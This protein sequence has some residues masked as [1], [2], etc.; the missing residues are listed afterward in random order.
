MIDHAR[1]RFAGTTFGRAGRASRR[2]SA[3]MLGIAVL[4][5]SMLAPAVAQ[6]TGELPTRVG[7]LSSF[8]GQV[9]IAPPDET[10]DWSPIDLNYPVTGGDNLWTG[11]GARAEIELGGSQLRMSASTNVNVAALDDHNLD[12]F[13]AQG[14]IIVRVA[15]LEPGDSAVIDTP[16]TQVVLR[17]P[18]LYRVFVSPDQQ[19]TSV[20]VREGE[21][22]AQVSAGLQQVLPGQT[23]TI[24]NAPTTAAQFSAAAPL[25]AFD[26]WSADRERTFRAAAP[27]YVSTQMV[28]YADLA[29]Y[30]TWQS[31]PDY[32]NV[33]FPTT[34][35]A[36]WAP[37]SDGYWTTIPG[38]G[39]T[40]VDRA[41]WGYAPFHYGRWV[42]VGARWGWVPGTYV[43]RPVWAPALVAWTGG[44]ITIAIGGGGPVYG[45]VPLGW[46]EPYNPWW[47]GC[48]GGC[49]DRY[50][51]PYRVDERYRD[52]APPP[53]R[54]ANWRVPGAV[55]A[56]A[57][58]NLIARKP[59]AAR[60]RV[61]LTGTQLNAVKP[62]TSVPPLTHARP[63][64]PRQV[65]AGAQGT[66]KPA[67]DFYA[68]S[69]PARLGIAHPN[70]GRGNGGAG[71][72]NNAAGA[73][74]TTAPR[75]RSAIGTQQHEK[76]EEA[77]V[78]KPPAATEVHAA[79]KGVGSPNDNNRGASRGGNAQPGSAPSGNAGAP[80]GGRDNRNRHA[81]RTPPAP[82]A[83]VAPSGNAASQGNP[84]AGAPRGQVTS[85]GTTN[86]SGQRRSESAGGAAR[87]SGNPQAGNAQR[88]G[89]GQHGANAQGGG[90]AQHGGSAQGGN[91][92][93]G[94]AT[95]QGGASAQRSGNAQGGGNV[96]RSG[97]PQGGANA[98][99]QHGGGNPQGGGNAH[100]G[101][102]NPQHE[103]KGGDNRGRNDHDNRNDRNDKQ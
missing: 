46:R 15:V 13:V 58:A 76:A 3:R 19:Q 50:N 4:A 95:P 57:G 10:Q 48:R 93:Q 45:W 52:H 84:A 74:A 21:L 66:P 56:V 82:T 14:D 68:N 64:D 49:W 81:E 42:H 69:K 16:T 86:A 70:A 87:S 18:G 60:E 1:L 32:G 89:S 9:F 37:Y 12:L 98:N 102:G 53:D 7:R 79:P 78:R 99:A 101:G 5:L 20:T 34:V 31:Y 65:R 100:Q 91:A 73:T 67:V 28:G 71:R 11:E 80:S 92:H 55:T 40:W 17:R 27:R 33:W 103:S 38:F 77:H 75:E 25:D 96:Q 6:D 51:R 72:G 22:T 59:Y 30:G 36:G 83:T 23:A 2:A 24:V 85:Q 90:N 29:T 47:G 43:A 26:A 88:G 8:A 94:G 44:G 39:L 54:Y 35:A 97:N 63:G 41:P 61:S 62:G